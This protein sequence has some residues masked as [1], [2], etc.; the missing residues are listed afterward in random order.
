MLLLWKACQIFDTCVCVVNVT[1][2]MLFTFSRCNG[3]K[4][5]YSLTDLALGSNGAAR[6]VRGPEADGAV[7]RLQE[8]AGAVPR[9]HRSQGPTQ[10]RVQH[11]GPGLRQEG[12]VHQG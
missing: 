5:P 9:L 6:H 4:I 3:P 1:K 11:R 12:T 2:T 10:A 7:G 8:Q